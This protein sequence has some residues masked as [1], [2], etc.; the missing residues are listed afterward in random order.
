LVT[1]PAAGNDRHPDPRAAEATIFHAPH[2]T[3]SSSC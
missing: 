3:N 2:A 1:H